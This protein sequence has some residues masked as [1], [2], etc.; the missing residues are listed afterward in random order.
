M[1]ILY[2][3]RI[4][5]TRKLTYHFQLNSWRAC[6]SITLKNACHYKCR[7][8]LQQC[9]SK[10]EI[11]IACCCSRIE[12]LNLGVLLEF[13]A[14]QIIWFIEIN[15]AQNNFDLGWQNKRIQ[16]EEAFLIYSRVLYWYFGG[17]FK[18]EAWYHKTRQKLHWSGKLTD[19]T[20]AYNSLTIFR[21]GS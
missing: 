14:S 19:H 16:G 18:L 8:L 13:N 4:Y 5:E 12:L 15:F 9:G 10:S 21:M 20:Y 11:C 7:R 2:V 6:N 1:Y 3:H 17:I